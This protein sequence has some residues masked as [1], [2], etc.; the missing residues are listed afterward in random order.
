M[1]NHKYDTRFKYNPKSYND[2][3]IDDTEIIEDEIFDKKKFS[4]LLYQKFP[5][6]F[7]L[8][9]S[10]NPKKKFKKLK[11]IKINILNKEKINDLPKKK[12]YFNK[13]KRN[14]T[15]PT[16]SNGNIVKKSKLDEHYENK[17]FK[18]FLNKTYE[19]E[20]KIINNDN[21]NCSD[22]ENSDNDSETLNEYDTESEL[23]YRSESDNSDKILSED[24]TMI[25]EYK[26]IF[27]SNNDS[28][29][30]FKKLNLD[31]KKKL[32]EKLKDLNEKAT[33]PTP[34]EVHVIN[35]NIDEKY[36]ISVFSKIKTLANLS[37]DTSSTEFIKLKNWIDIFM[38]IPFN[39]YCSLPITINDG[40]SN[41]KDYMINAKNILDNAVY[42]LNDAKMQLL[43]FIAQLINNPHANGLVLG[44]KGPMGTGKTTLIKDGIS[45]ILNRPFHFIPLAGIRDGTYF[46]GHSYTYEG[47]RHGK[48]VDILIQTKCMNP[49]IY[50][51][52]LDKVSSTNL[53]DEIIGIL[54][55]LTDV[56]QSS[57][58]NDKYFSEL[59][60]NLNKV[61]YI[62][63]YNDENAISPILRD[64]MYKIETL[65]YSTEDKLVIAKSH[66]IPKIIKELN[67]NF[68]IKLSD[69]NIKF[70][71]NN[72]TDNEKG[73]RNLKRCLETIYNKLNLYNL[74]NDNNDFKDTFFKNFKYDDNVNE[75]M[76]KILLSSFTSKTNNV[77]FGMYN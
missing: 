67:A 11:N 1:V 56:T 49:I 15:S 68:N 55:H 20:N 64:R 48:I 23:S 24:K 21:S 61:I 72:Y 32:L 9:K 31:D 50:G 28:I 57:Q 14:C 60:F 63:S 34:Y 12:Y 40:I 76:I 74:V 62:F 73:V 45:K 19:D 75:N 4:K 39:N 71:I 70:I 42:G 59:N 10:K 58:F 33:I 22:S 2:D 7:T 29:G 30:Y 36:K 77:P 54:T 37:N 43:Q 6:K 41:C 44:I 46:E 27:K 53:G 8:E 66:L 5:S 17:S 13:L 65:G 47:S 69:E 25:K 26:N 52:E 51:D 3:F 35:S 18:I 16:N 38:K